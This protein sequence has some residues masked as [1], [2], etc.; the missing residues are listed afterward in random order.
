[1]KKQYKKA[2]SIRRNKSRRQNTKKTYK[3]YRRGGVA[4]PVAIATN[5]QIIAI[6]ACITNAINRTGRDEGNEGSWSCDFWVRENNTYKMKIIGSTRRPTN[7]ILIRD[8]SEHLSRKQ[9][10]INTCLRGIPLSIYNL[11][12]SS[13]SLHDTRRLLSETRDE[14]DDYFPDPDYN[15]DEESEFWNQSIHR[16]ITFSVRRAPVSRD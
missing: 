8:F 10:E 5:P 15:I 1:M 6:S 13:I 12:I 16:L 7:E 11:N 4:P 2:R 14:D 9:S 3:R